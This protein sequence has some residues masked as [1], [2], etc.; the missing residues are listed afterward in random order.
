MS[1]VTHGLDD[2]TLIEMLRTG[3][4]QAQDLSEEQHKSVFGCARRD[5]AQLKIALMRTI[6]A[7]ISANAKLQALSRAS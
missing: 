4:I 6:R 1:D 2:Q 5:L 7:D 3:Q